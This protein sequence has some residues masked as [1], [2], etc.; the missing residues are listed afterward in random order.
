M[1]GAIAVMDVEIDNRDALGAVSGLT[2]RA[3]IAALLKKQNPMAVASSAWWPG[4]RVATK[5]LTAL[6]VITSS[7]A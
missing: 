2:W 5:A 1:L 7:T 6:P 3:A 4:G